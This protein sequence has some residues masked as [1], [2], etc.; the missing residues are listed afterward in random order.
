MV[1]LN[2][3]ERSSMSLAR[4]SKGRLWHPASQGIP[5]WHSQAGGSVQVGKRSKEAKSR[6]WAREMGDRATAVAL[7]LVTFCQRL[8]TSKT[9][10]I[11][12]E[13]N[14]WHTRGSR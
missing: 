4:P 10:D 8:I 7:S 5:R 14:I 6:P 9:S 11:Q 12:E 2:L 13:R 1:M 3:D